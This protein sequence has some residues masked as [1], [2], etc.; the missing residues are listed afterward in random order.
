MGRLNPRRTAGV[1]VLVA[2]L[3]LGGSAS[4]AVAD[5]GGSHSDRDSS[6][7]R[8][9]GGSNG[10][11][12]LDRDGDIRDGNVGK[13]E[14]GDDWNGAENTGSIESPAVRIGSG[15]SGV[16]DVAESA[17]SIASG[18]GGADSGESR[19]SG[20]DASGFGGAAATG[21]S[22]SDRAGA[23]NGRFSPPR[24]TVGNGRAPGIQRGESEPRWRAP[25]P[26]PAPAAPP[27]PP[28][29]PPPAPAPPPSWVNRLPA[30][31]VLTQQMGAP[32]PA[33]WS[34]PLWGLAGLLLIPA[35]GAVLGYRQARAAHAA[36]RLRRS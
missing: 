29:P 21:G 4:M 10:R 34:D 6:S 9:N 8:G 26:Q 36:E 32:R 27:P 15:R 20:S 19:L 17:P 11:G 23:P 31:P 33:D 30:P 25:A 2:F 5:P 13:R 7:D 1:G 35:A 14:E 3:L 18:S 22:G 24:V 16:A 12:E 28:P